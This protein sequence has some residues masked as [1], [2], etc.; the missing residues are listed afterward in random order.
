[1]KS[2]GA[3]RLILALLR[4]EDLR[5]RGVSPRSG[6]GLHAR[7]QPPGCGHGRVRGE[8]AAQVS[9]HHRRDVFV[10]RILFSCRCFQLLSDSRPHWHTTGKEL[11]RPDFPRGCDRPFAAAS[12][13]QS[14]RRPPFAAE[15]LDADWPPAQVLRL[16]R[17]PRRHLWSGRQK[18][19]S[20]RNIRVWARNGA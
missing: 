9:V 8:H 7:Q 11:R 2:D 5:L 20:Y 4:S 19:S 12:F 17:P 13:G 14:R 3:W 18:L 15:T 10:F 1:M 16:L 6:G